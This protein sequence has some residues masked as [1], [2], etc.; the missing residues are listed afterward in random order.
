MYL[1]QLGMPMRSMMAALAA[2]AALA[3]ALSFL[4]SGTFSVESVIATGKNN[5]PDAS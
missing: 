3:L 4:G 1:E 5:S 2:G